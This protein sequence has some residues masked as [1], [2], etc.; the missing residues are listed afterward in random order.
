LSITALTSALSVLSQADSLS[1]IEDSSTLV[2]VTAFLTTYSEKPVF[3]IDLAKITYLKIVGDVKK[4]KK[5]PFS[6]AANKK[7]LRILKRQS[8][9]Y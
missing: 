1:L 6:L 2:L 5:L 8:P 9:S 7:R 4:M 3:S